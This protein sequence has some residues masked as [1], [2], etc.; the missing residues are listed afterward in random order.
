MKGRVPRHCGDSRRSQWSSLQGAPEGGRLS[1]H[2]YLSRLDIINS[3][4]DNA[5]VIWAPASVSSLKLD[6]LFPV[7]C[8]DLGLLASTHVEYDEGAGQKQGP[9][10]GLPGG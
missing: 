8:G 9:F 1:D 6:S 3:E 7:F 2:S 4:C 10:L 5:G